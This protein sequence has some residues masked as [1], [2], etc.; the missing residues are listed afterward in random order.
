M[1]SSDHMV[2]AQLRRQNILACTRNQD[3][4]VKLLLVHY[5][6]RVSAPQRTCQIALPH[7]SIALHHSMSRECNTQPYR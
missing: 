2:I 4:I 7:P 1:R 5:C 3:M 6:R